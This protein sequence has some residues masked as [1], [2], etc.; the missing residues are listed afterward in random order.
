MLTTS[1]H[2]QMLLN[3]VLLQRAQL[4]V[5]FRK[6]DLEQYLHFWGIRVPMN[7]KNPLSRKVKGNPICSESGRYKTCCHLSGIRG[8]RFGDNERKCEMCR[9]SSRCLF[10]SEFSCLSPPITKR[11]ETYRFNFRRTRCVAVTP[12][13][14]SDT[15]FLWC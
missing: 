15:F 5:I 4:N 2:Q 13:V 12:A 11:T 8:E 14:N 3:P 1:L 6:A 10:F 9:D 7:E